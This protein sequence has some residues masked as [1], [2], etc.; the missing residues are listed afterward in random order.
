MSEESNFDM[1]FES[2]EEMVTVSV[3]ATTTLQVI[4]TLLKKYV[5]HYDWVGFYMV[6]PKKER[7]LVLG[8]YSGAHTDHT[9]I[10][11]GKGIC[12][13]AAERGETFLIQDVSKE[14]NYLS[15]SINVKSEIVVPVFRDGKV[16]GQIDI[17]S[18]Q[19]EPFTD[20]D[21]EFLEKLAKLVSGLM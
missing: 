13:Q 3:K 11:F 9:R 2:I 12:G 18:H 7:K 19:L 21:K 14:D 17:D 20:E 8:P 15:C 16:V 4:T 5:P 1:L 6:D 10:P